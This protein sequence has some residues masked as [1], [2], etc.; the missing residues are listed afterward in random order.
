MRQLLCS[1]LVGREPDIEDLE[2]A[3][4][5]A[6]A[7]RGNVILLSGEAGVGKT[8]LVREFMASARRRS[9]SVLVGRAT[10]SR[11]PPAFGPFTEALLSYF[12]ASGPPDAAD[13]QAFKP[14][15]GRLIPQ[16]R[17]ADPP[18]AGD[19]VVVLAEAVVRLLSTIA[20]DRGCLLVLEDLHWADPETIA[21]VDYFSE[22]LH[23]ERVLCVGTFRSDEPGE[24]SGLWASMHARRSGRLH[25]LRRLDD[26]CVRTIT[27]VCLGGE[28]PDEVCEAITG[29]A[30]GLPF[31]VEE[32][33]A[34]WA[35]SG[36][37][38]QS[39]S[40][41]SLTGQAGPVVPRTFAET[42]RRR[43]RAIGESARLVLGAGAV[44]GPTFDWRLVV[45]ATGVDEGDVLETL[46]RAV[47]A[48]LCVAEPHK[49]GDFRFR[50]ALTR[51]AV[52]GELL[53]VE[54]RNVAGALLDALERGSPNLSGDAAQQAVELAQ[55][56]GDE[57]R[58]ARL[59]LTAAEDARSR[60]ALSTAETFLQRARTLTGHDGALVPAIDHAL[61]EVLVAA[62][63]PLAAREIGE[64]LLR[65]DSGLHSSELAV[66]LLT[67]ARAATLGGLWHQAA[68]HVAEARARSS[69]GDEGFCAQID[70]TEAH[71]LMAQKRTTEATALAR[72]ALDA[73]T[74]AA[75]PG[76]AGE[77][78]MIVGRAE[79]LHDLASARTAFSHAL[80]MAQR[81]GHVEA[82]IGAAFEL[83]TIPLLDGGPIEPLLEVRDSAVAAGVP[84]TAAYVD[85]MLAHR[86]EDQLELE[87]AR[88]MAQRCA[89][90]ARRFRLGPLFGSACTQ[91]A[92]A[93]GALGDRPAMEEALATASAT[94]GD[95]PDVVAGMHIARGMVALVS[96]DRASSMLHLD[97]AMDVLRT[98][99]AT[100][101]APHRALWALLHVVEDDGQADEALT[102]VKGS[103]ATVHRAVRGLMACAEAVQLGRRGHP[104]EAGELWASGEADLSHFQ[105][106]LHMARRLGAEGAI[107]DGWGD[108]ISWLSQA[109]E[110]FDDRA[111]PRVATAC[112]SLLRTAGGPVTRRTRGHDGVPDDLSQAGLTRREV[113]VLDLLAEGLSTTAIAARLYLSVKT[114][115]RHT[116]NLATKLQLHGRAQVVAF[117][118]A[119]RGSRTSTGHGE[120]ISVLKMGDAPMR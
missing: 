53:A 20:D 12:R 103:A 94:A 9:F 108:P 25:D 73:A 23:S 76:I 65:S 34:A 68:Q 21:I 14:A 3:L 56:A 78:L 1:S 93:H 18:S 2:A 112:R 30:D 48:Q 17:P 7:G 89:E 105:G 36:S 69:P 27:E 28:V 97:A 37:L 84:V 42:V 100:Y 79:R 51:H 70:L 72:K 116:A 19:S 62:G 111:M 60:G 118:A 55:A 5:E 43:L 88:E 87:A 95:D 85:L 47:T 46:R 45:D 10:D 80:E 67:L 119:R 63:K 4:D 41:W 77:A 26:G 33:L 81:S 83:A 57:R 109:G 110:F 44:L 6:R 38:A 64:R 106:R 91:L 39:A 59:L 115:E 92:F 74:E 66:L 114:V 35:D 15:L 107:R 113:E 13:L 54:R 11:T 120:G 32:L 58:A 40:G 96:E 8:R 90:A 50:H 117:A 49:G 52:L 75:L 71:A 29:F 102:E 99:Q 16:W 98:S 86:Y 22:T 24:A 82:R 31:L 61:T 101:P 104:C